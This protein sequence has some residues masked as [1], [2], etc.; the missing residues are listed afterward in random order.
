[1]IKDM[2]NVKVRRK[3]VI[4]FM[5][6]MFSLACLV[7]IYTEINE[8]KVIMGDYEMSYKK[9]DKENNEY[10]FKDNKGQE[11]LF[12]GDYNDIKLVKSMK[13]EG[14]LY[15]LRVNVDL[16]YEFYEDDMVIDE[17]TA[18]EVQGGN[19]SQENGNAYLLIEAFDIIS[20]VERYIIQKI[21]LIQLVLILIAAFM[22]V[23]PIYFWKIGY[24]RRLNKNEPS[25]SGIVFIRL[26]SIFITL[27]VV[28][29]PLLRVWV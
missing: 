17:F 27:I 15:Q 3:R 14:V 21:I 10:I 29:F 4:I 8:R 2:G 11:V 6:I 26:Q 18:I 1:M 16:V 24:Y 19:F 25:K 23:E 9:F 12:K 5:A 28:A 22:F 7:S 20:K 13:L